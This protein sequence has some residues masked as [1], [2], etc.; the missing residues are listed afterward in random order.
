MKPAL[1]STILLSGLLAI[2]CGKKPEAP[3]ATAQT[4]VAPAPEV[5]TP[6]PNGRVTAQ[7]LAAYITARKSIEAVIVAYSDSITATPDSTNS[8]IHDRYK[9][10]CDSKS[11]EA[12]LVGGYAEFQW[13]SGNLK[14]SVNRPLYDSLGMSGNI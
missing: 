13:I 12:G 7:Q 14:A 4:T 3:V 10:Q 8:A 2:G 1:I 6:D 11:K 5:F 9:A